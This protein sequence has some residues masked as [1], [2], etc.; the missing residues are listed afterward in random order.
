MSRWDIKNQNEHA[1]PKSAPMAHTVCETV[2]VWRGEAKGEIQRSILN[3]NDELLLE[4]AKRFAKVAKDEMAFNVESG[5]VQDFQN[6]I[7]RIIECC[8][9][10]DWFME[11]S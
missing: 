4:V 9:E 11:N 3:G 1:L 5:E 6:L 8:D 10:N 7:E 2:F